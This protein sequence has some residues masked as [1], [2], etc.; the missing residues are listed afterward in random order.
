M[1]HK[2]K[3]SQHYQLNFLE[4]KWDLWNYK[5]HCAGCTLKFI[6][7]MY[8]SGGMR[9]GNFFGRSMGGGGSWGWKKAASWLPSHSLTPP[10][11]WGGVRL[12][13]GPGQHPN[14]H[15]ELLGSRNINDQHFDKRN[16]KTF[17]KLSPFPN[18]EW[19]YKNRWNDD[20]IMKSWGLN[21]WWWLNGQHPIKACDRHAMRKKGNRSGK[22]C[23]SRGEMLLG[24][25]KR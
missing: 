19:W 4:S 13:K 12:K 24:E 25:K 9:S 11:G 8:P 1:L 14:S 20:G 21:Q 7:P 22:N 15:C 10:R 17:C 6:F 16:L 3:H 2:Q 5:I 23:S 18:C